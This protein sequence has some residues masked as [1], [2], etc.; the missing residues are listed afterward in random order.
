MS[1][2]ISELETLLAQMIAEHRKLLG[3]LEIQQAGMKKL[4]LKK[5]NDSANLQEPCR[6]RIAMLERNR[7]ALVAQLAAAMR[8]EG[9]LT[10][11]R[12]A[13]L[14]PPRA[15]ALLKLRDELKAVAE[16]V[17]TRAQ[18]AGRVAGAVLGHLN[19]VIR[20]L[21]GAIEKAGLYT[22]NGVP[23]VS[24]RIGVMEAVG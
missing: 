23:Q 21:A 11:A 13:V 22:K 24:S 5:M 9:D 20:L 12:L 6:L 1:R 19:T 14:F 17:R 15:Q 7:R 18:I 10:I 2:Q 4:D 8:V 3:Y 16:Q